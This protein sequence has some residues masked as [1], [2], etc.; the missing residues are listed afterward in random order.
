M[1]WV[2]LGNPREANEELMQIAPGLQV[3][4]DVLEIR[5]EICALAKEWDA[6]VHIASAIVELAPNRPSGW[7][8]R[9]YSLRRVEGGGLVAA[10][11][12]LLL[13]ADE[14]PAEPMIPFA[15]SCYTCQMGRL[16]DA[17]A[18]LHRAFAVA[19]MMG[20]KKRLKHM[21]LEEPD[22]QPLWRKI[23][24]RGRQLRPE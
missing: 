14:F 21:A 18:W 13:V 9:A 10:F 1:G 8:G 15:L 7:I 19:S 4:P 16:E 24:K 3:H 23:P 17:R 20:T 22:L 5:W 11:M 2:E 12:T 6:C